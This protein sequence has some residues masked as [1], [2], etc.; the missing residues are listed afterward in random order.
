ML[1]ILFRFHNFN[2][3]FEDDNLWV[4]FI[5]INF[6]EGHWH[7]QASKRLVFYRR[8]L[9]THICCNKKLCILYKVHWHLFFGDIRYT[10]STGSD[11]ST[12]INHVGAFIAGLWAITL[13]S[14][15][16]P[17]ISIQ[18][19]VFENDVWKTR[20]SRLDLKSPPCNQYRMSHDSVL[21]D[22]YTVLN[23]WL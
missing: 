4:Y 13:N 18:E 8:N 1:T 21:L 2:T 12:I 11:N 23:W 6:I 19:N 22:S 15:G 9:P 10:N 7:F 20:Q 5:K 16:N 14:N 3:P 17:N